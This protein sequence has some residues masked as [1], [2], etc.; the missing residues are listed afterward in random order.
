[1]SGLVTEAVI[2]ARSSNGAGDGL[3]GGFEIEALRIKLTARPS[4]DVFV[5]IVERIVPD[6][7]EVG[8]A[9]RSADIFERTGS[10]ALDATRVFDA[11]LA[12]GD[13][14]RHGMCPAVAEV[15]LVEDEDRRASKSKAKSARLTSLASNVRRPDTG[16]S[17]RSC[18]FWPS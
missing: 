18:D 9:R 5:L 8:V 12:P 15:V 4:A 16:E 13:D 1:M 14:H 6:F 2:A 3:V 17:A 7:E 11:R 10:A